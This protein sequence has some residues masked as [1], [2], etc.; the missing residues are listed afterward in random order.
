MPPIRIRTDIAYFLG[1]QEHLSLPFRRWTGIFDWN[2]GTRKGI[3]NSDFYHHWKEA[4]AKAGWIAT[5]LISRN[6]SVNGISSY[7]SS[8]FLCLDSHIKCCLRA[9]PQSLITAGFT[10][11]K[12]QAITKL[13]ATHAKQLTKPSYSN[14]TRSSTHKN[15]EYQ[16]IVHRAVNEISASDQALGQL[17][18][19]AAI[20]SVLGGRFNG[21]DSGTIESAGL[22]RSVSQG[23]SVSAVGDRESV[24]E[25][26][27]IADAEF[28]P[29][30][31][32]F[33]RILGA[34]T[35]C[36]KTL[37]SYRSAVV[38]AVMASCLLPLGRLFTNR[39]GKKHRMQLLN[40]LL[41]LSE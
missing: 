41:L 33:K 11:G 32:V 22:G 24:G 31:L 4:L 29:F 34:C 5:G 8:P 3:T 7:Q 17:S 15:I 19:S 30:S 10:T 23:L 13:Q 9:Y 25:K 16:Y 39:I 21:N 27:T 35:D 12:S 18:V 36:C 20:E 37:Q 38:L 2:E 14:R 28:W 40:A 26:D 1:L 6:P